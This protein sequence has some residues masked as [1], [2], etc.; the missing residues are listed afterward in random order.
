MISSYTKR[1]GYCFCY[2]TSPIIYTICHHW[3]TYED[4]GTTIFKWALGVFFSSFS[5]SVYLDICYQET[6]LALFTYLEKRILDKVSFF[7]Q[8]EACHEPVLRKE[9]TLSF[10]INGLTMVLQLLC[11]GTCNRVLYHGI[12][13]V[14]GRP[15]LGEWVRKERPQEIA[16]IPLCWEGHLYTTAPDL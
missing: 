16:K 4:P 9:K 8:S 1:M 10:K 12:V 2:F 13:I 5:F 7:D 14:P 3:F 15:C 6:L 11:Q